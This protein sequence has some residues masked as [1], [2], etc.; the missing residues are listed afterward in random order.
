MLISLI[1]CDDHCESIGMPKPDSAQSKYIHA[2][3]NC[4]FIC[5]NL[6]KISTKNMK[7]FKPNF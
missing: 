3:V 4:I 6:N 7:N 1:V 5:K 2:F